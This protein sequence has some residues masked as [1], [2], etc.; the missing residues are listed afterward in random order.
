[1]TM[2]RSDAAKVAA[3]TRW[4]FEPDRR[5]ATSAGTTAFLAKFE[6]LVDPDGLLSPEERTK[7]ARNALSAHMTRIR[8]KRR[9]RRTTRT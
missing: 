8:A 4:A 3:H 5:S 7:R 2:S 1:M 6:Q 9:P